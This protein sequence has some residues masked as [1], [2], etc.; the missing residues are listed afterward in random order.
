MAYCVLFPTSFVIY[1]VIGGLYADRSN[2]A[3]AMSVELADRVPRG[4]IAYDTCSFPRFIMDPEIST[5][6]LRT[7]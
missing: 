2:N 6:E 7:L 1:I 5:T 4:T 3:L